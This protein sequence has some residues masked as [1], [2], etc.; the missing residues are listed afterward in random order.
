MVNL[1]RLQLL[2]TGLAAISS[3]AILLAATSG[4]GIGISSDSTYYLAAAQSFARGQGF[5]DISGNPY[6]YWPP[7]YPVLIGAILRL[8]GA[9]AMTIALAINA[10]ALGGINVVTA[11]LLKRCFPENDRWWYLGMAV[12]WLYLGYQS[13]AANLGTDLLYIY[14][15]S[16]FCLVGQNLLERRQKSGVLHLSLLALLGSLLRWVGLALVVAEGL[17]ILIAFRNQFK[18]AVLYSLTSCS[19]AALPVLAWLF[20]RNYLVYGTLFGVDNQQYVSIGV[21][22]VFSLERITQWFLPLSV[23]RALDP[24]LIILGISAVLLLANRVTNWKRWGQRLISF[25]MVAVILPV[26]VYFLAMLFTA[27]ST[28]HYETFDDRYQ[29]PM[30]L[31]ILVGLF[32]TL[33]ELVLSHFKGRWRG[34]ATPVFTGLFLVWLIYPAS[35][36]YGFTLQSRRNG[37]IFHNAY[38]TRAMWEMPLVDR[39]KSLDPSLPVYSN[40]YKAI[41]LFTGREVQR[42]PYDLKSYRADPNNLP[43]QYPHWPPEEQA[44]LIWLNMEDN[45]AYFNP[46]ELGTIARLA[47]LYKGRDGQI[48]LV[49]PGVP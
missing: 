46:D 33:D 35:Q 11:I 18:R 43:K 19:A 39:L 38:N 13:L 14:L 31:A 6:L 12:S 28:D 42:S 44:Y 2:L 5:L 17:F 37:V 24:R 22:L 4:F 7:L 3:I 47:R 49:S 40:Y 21:N 32:V 16:I 20:G 23:I 27:V 25:H 15:Q 26:V 36:L 48:F 9:P 8:T 1:N 34:Y 29:A 45:P 41:F 30:F 10:L